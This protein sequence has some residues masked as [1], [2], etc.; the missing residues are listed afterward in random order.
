MY[1]AELNIQGVAL[2]IGRPELSDFLH[3]YQTNFDFQRTRTHNK[4]HGA[5]GCGQKK[6]S[7]M[8]L[9]HKLLSAPGYYYPSQAT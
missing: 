5:M 1:Y 2:N 7:A 6:V 9:Y 3:Y 8:W 4:V